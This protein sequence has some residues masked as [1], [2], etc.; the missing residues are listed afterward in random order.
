MRIAVVGAGISGL[1][2]AY[3]LQ[4]QHHVT[5]FEANPYAGG[6]TNTVEVE[7][8]GR[9]YAIDTGFV[10]FNERN[11]PNFCSLLSELGVASRPTTM[12]F[13][14]RDDSTGME[15]NG[16][17][18]NTFFAQRANLVRPSF[19]RMLT[20]ILRFQRE[21]ARAAAALPQTTTVREF[22]VGQ[23]YSEAFAKQYLLPMGSAIWSCPIGKFEEFP[24]RF[25]VEFYANHGL[26]QLRNRPEWRTIEGGSQTYVRQMLRR[27]RNPVRLRTPVARVQR[28]S[29]RVDIWTCSGE[30]AT[31]DHVV[32]ACHSDHALKLLGAGATRTEREVL[33]AFPYERNVAVLHTDQ[34]LLPKR[35]K[36]WASWN[37]R[38]VAPSL[39]ASVTYNM[40]ILQGIKSQHTFCVTLNSPIRI[41][42]E[43]ILGRYE[44]SHPVFDHRRFAAQS[45]HSELLN[46][47]RTSFCGAYWGSGF[48]EDGVN[49]ALAVVRA[50]EQTVF[51]SGLTDVCGSDRAMSSL[52]AARR[53]AI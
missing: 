43:Q 26:L 15:Y 20:D 39:S 19:L 1:A 16:H 29:D 44:Y 48:H 24:I 6:H 8:G 22:L 3:W 51:Q 2:A 45:R 49:S 35:R 34:S 32:L 36:A 53:E 31:F 13:S 33:T 14:V 50:I 10:V 5:V 11:Y 4:R 27:F 21:A 9:C 17:S 42:E 28:L 23:G 25:I 52:A 7:V 18:V 41:A 30:L 12:S 38:L 37:Y 46:R 47:N 40:N